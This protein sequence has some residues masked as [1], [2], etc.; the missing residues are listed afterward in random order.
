MRTKTCLSLDDAN[1]MVAAAK[2][3]A[4]KNQWVVAIAVVDDA[5]FLLH[6]ERLDGASAGSPEIATLKARTAALTR[7]P[8]KNAEEVVKDRPA[9]LSL[10]GRVPVQG[11]LPIFHQ[12]ECVGG[13]GVST[14]RGSPEDE[15][16][17]Q[18]GLAGS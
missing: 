14:A 15:Q 18:A 6:L 12:G 13:I 9:T 1:R 7:A 16:V 11:G 8:S 17:A 3:E 10:P 2:A 5:G 4:A